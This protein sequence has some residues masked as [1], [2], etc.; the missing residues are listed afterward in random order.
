MMPAGK[1]ARMVGQN[2]V[3]DVGELALS[4]F[5]IVIGISAFVFF[6]ALSLGVRNV[7]LGEDL[8][9]L[10]RLE[11]IA[12]KTNIGVALGK[13]LDDG[14]V[15]RIRARP[16]VQQ[17]IPRMLLTFPASGSGDFEGKDIKFE[18][19]G[20]CDGIEPAF[21]EDEE[22]AEL[23]RD[24]ETPEYLASADP[25]KLRY[26]YRCKDAKQVCGADQ[27]CRPADPK[28]PVPAVL[29]PCVRYNDYYCEDRTHHYCDERDLKC[30][31]RVP[32]IV[33]PALIEIFNGSFAESHDLPR[34][35]RQGVD[36]FI[37]LRGYAAMRFTIGLG[38]TYV[39]GS[40]TRITAEP[41][42]MEGYLVGSTNKAM[43]IG[44]TIPIEYVK[45]WNKEYQ[46][47]KEAHTYSSIIVEVKGKDRIASFTAWLRNVEKLELEDSQGERFAMAIFIVT[48]LFVLI[49]FTIVLISAIN[50]AHTFF[51]QVSERRRE[52]GL[53]RALG[54][55][56]ADV[57]LLIIGE[58]AII[59]LVGGTIG[60]VLARLGGYVIDFASANWFP[61]FPFKPATYFDFHWMILAGGLLFAVLFAVIGGFLPARRAARLEPAQAL[62]AQ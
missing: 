25:C 44:M 43:P 46:G 48:T 47:D 40:N 39:A 35:P 12:P 62:A 28:A 58:S 27:L 30:H 5:G 13:T 26:K 57:R 50:I 6:L 22:F 19:G 14:V 52:L 11:V 18:V 61:D 24:W 41:R 60:V 8:F 21:V 36:Y 56:Q 45:R 20:F 1:L 34:I 37:K 31:H 17:A 7:I 49:S 32:V 2:T 9:P 15:E 16:E 38:E 55:S 3:R 10:E 51:M 4:S 33:S 59:G 23:F 53:L 29:E 54:A 42:E